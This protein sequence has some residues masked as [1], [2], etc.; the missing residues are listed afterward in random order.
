MYIYFIGDQPRGFMFVWHGLSWK[1]A[2]VAVA[3]FVVIVSLLTPYTRP[4]VD[5]VREAWIKECSIPECFEDLYMRTCSTMFS[6]TRPGRLR[7]EQEGGFLNSLICSVSATNCR[8][9]DVYESKHEA[10]YDHG[11]AWFTRVLMMAT[12]DACVSEVYSR[13]HHSTLY[14]LCVVLAGC[15]GS[16]CFLELHRVT[17]EPLGSK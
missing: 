13:E 7:S 17:V 4:T 10:V 5:D 3:V 2:H 16:L 6:I 1:R 12:K 11:H 8:K 14:L 15:I 9:A